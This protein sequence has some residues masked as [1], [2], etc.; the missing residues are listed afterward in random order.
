MEE[1]REI[2]RIGEEL[3]IQ[4]LE[5]VHLL[6]LEGVEPRLPLAALARRRGAGDHAVR[7]RDDPRRLAGSER[8]ERG[9]HREGR[10]ARAVEVV[11]ME[12]AVVDLGLELPHEAEYLLCR[13]Q[14]VEL[15]VPEAT[16]L[17]EP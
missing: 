14:L 2:L 1:P 7:A 17:A 12:A 9:D 3:L 16:G 4:L 11:L 10:V 15:H 8:L 5:T 6:G 13:R